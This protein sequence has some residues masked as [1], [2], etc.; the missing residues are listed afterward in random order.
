MVLCEYTVWCSLVSMLKPYWLSISVPDRAAFALRCGTSFAHLRNIAY[1]QKLCGEKLAIAIERESAGAVRC[2]S[3]RP[4]VD[5]AY[6]RGTQPDPTD[7]H[8]P[9]RQCDCAAG[10]P[11]F[12]DETQQEAA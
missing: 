1:G 3:L 4:D 8:P 11:S 2:E 10:A 9:H 12:A 6:L 5:W 7:P